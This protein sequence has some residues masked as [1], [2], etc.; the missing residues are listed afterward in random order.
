M[1]TCWNQHVP[2]KKSAEYGW[3]VWLIR[4]REN[5]WYFHPPCRSPKTAASHKKK[6]QHFTCNRCSPF[7]TE[8]SEQYSSLCA[9]LYLPTFAAPIIWYNSDGDIKD[10][11]RCSQVQLYIFLN[12]FLL[13]P[14][15]WLSSHARLEA[16]VIQTELNCLPTT[17]F[18][19]KA[20]LFYS[21]GGVLCGSESNGW[22]K[23]QTN[24]SLSIL[25]GLILPGCIPFLKAEKET[26]KTHTMWL[27]LLYT[28]IVQLWYTEIPCTLLAW[29]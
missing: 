12:G 27:L 18:H 10:N 1:I 24:V 3:P 26:S 19:W 23:T 22:C 2:T 28:K 16:F 8:I 6:A 7:K 21:P 20:F 25:V 29:L 4:K 5:F 11:T 17:W 13:G 9:G 15:D 14:I